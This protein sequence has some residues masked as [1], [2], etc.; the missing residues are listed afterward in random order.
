[1]SSIISYS[2][3]DT[4]ALKDH[5]ALVH[6]S[7]LEWTSDSLLPGSLLMYRLRLNSDANEKIGFLIYPPCCQEEDAALILATTLSRRMDQR[8]GLL[9][10]LIVLLKKMIVKVLA[11]NQANYVK[12]SSDLDA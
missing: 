8:Y 3:G 7:K 10:L 11:T 4:E 12:C 1:M 6:L 5:G 9:S 2:E